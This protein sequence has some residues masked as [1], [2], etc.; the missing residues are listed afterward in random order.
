RLYGWLG[1]ALVLA[2][3]IAPAVALAGEDEDFA[4]FED[5][6]KKVEAERGA[7]AD[8]IAKLGELATKVVDQCLED[9][10]K[11][12]RQARLDKAAPLTSVVTLRAGNNEQTLVNVE[13][14]LAKVKDS[15]AR[16]QLLN[17]K[18]VALRNL[19]RTEEFN[20]VV[21]E[22]RAMQQKMQEEADA[23]KPKAGQEAPVF[24]LKDLDGNDVEL[25]SL[26]GKIVLL[27]F[28]ATWCGPCKSIMASFLKPLHDEFKDRGVVIL[29]V[30]TNW[31]GDTAEKQKKFA[32]DTNYHWM[33]VYDADGEVTKTYQVNGIP[34]L[35]LIDKEGK[36][37]IYGGGGDTAKIREYLVANAD[38]VAGSGDGGKP[39]TG[40]DR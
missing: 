11:G 22:I 12:E 16:F 9:V 10:T 18:G 17:H 13:K 34:T 39:E 37:V 20:A 25:K 28:W 3:M 36:I 24:T 21:T 15:N 8:N 2:F 31:R 29:G 19:G 30:G 1:I 33:K 5:M 35:V 27:D 4:A 40:G 14:V 38:P 23:K 6:L 26:R 32:H 7:N